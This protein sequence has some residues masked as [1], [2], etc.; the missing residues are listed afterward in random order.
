MRGRRRRF[1]GTW[2]PNIGTPATAPSIEDMSNRY[3]SL[4]IPADSRNS[5]LGIIPIIRDTPI[6]QSGFVLDDIVGN[7][8]A[9]RRIVGKCFVAIRGALDVSAGTIGAVHG[10]FQ[11]TA[12]FFIARAEDASIT[13]DAPIGGIQPRDYGPEALNTIR[14]PWIWR[15]QWVLS[16]PV[17]KY[18]APAAMGAFLAANATGVADALSWPPSNAGYGSIQDGPHFDAKTRRR[19]RQDERLFFA[20]QARGLPV[21]TVVTQA[22]EARVWLD[23]RVFGALRKARQIGTF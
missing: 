2:L 1:K 10:T 5:I 19:V 14:E 13:V 15:R 16:D 12:G 8:Y 17:L 11:V 4:A 3:V 20:V 7:E 9:I 23:Y 18:G 21:N 22:S 6:E